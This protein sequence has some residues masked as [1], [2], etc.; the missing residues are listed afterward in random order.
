MFSETLKE[1]VL[2]CVQMTSCGHALTAHCFVFL[3]SCLGLALGP[4]LVAVATTPAAG[5]TTGK[6]A[7][8]ILQYFQ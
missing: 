3:K 1:L 6:N 4:D 2:K 5:A 7:A 8:H